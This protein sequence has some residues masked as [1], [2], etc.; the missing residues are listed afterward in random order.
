MAF[1]HYKTLTLDKSQAGGANSTNWPL[2][3]CLN[4]D[5]QAVDPD[6]ATVANGGEVQNANGYDIRPYA[7]VNLTTPLDFELVAYDAASGALEMHVK[8]PTLNSAVDT[9]IYLAFGDS[10]ITTDGSSGA[11]TFSNGFV[12]VWHLAGGDKNSVTGNTGTTTGATYGAG[13]V[14]GGAIFAGSTDNIQSDLN[15]AVP[16]SVTWQAW[17]YRTGSGANIRVAELGLGLGIFIVGSAGVTFFA[18][19][20][21]GQG[22][23]AIAA[24]G[25]ST[26]YNVAVAYDGSNPANDPTFRVNGVD[27]GLSADNNTTG[28]LDASTADLYLGN[29][30]PSLDRGFEGTLDEIRLSNVLRGEAWLTADYYS[31]RAS[32]TFI[33]WGA[34]TAVM[35]FRLTRFH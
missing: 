23:W 18:T 10:G 11:N 4:N 2:A 31:Q 13:R 24:L 12:G 32:S 19:F 21:G 8:I 1:S 25:T 7:N 28:T 30:S 6:L 9:V 35:P 14:A 26:W 22:N 27:P 15:I 5:V 29:R 16:S 33:A 3:I 17:T 34:L 20:S